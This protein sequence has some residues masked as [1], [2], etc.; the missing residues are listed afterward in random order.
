[1][2]KEYDKQNITNTFYDIIIC[3]DM[4]AGQLEECDYVDKRYVPQDLVGACKK[5]IELMGYDK[6]FKDEPN[7]KY[8]VVK[9]EE[10]NDTDWQTFYK[11]YKYRGKW[12]Y[13]RVDY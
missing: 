11:V 5:V 12:K 3:A 4:G 2:A 8:L 6:D 10:D 1:M 13:K 7:W 9:H